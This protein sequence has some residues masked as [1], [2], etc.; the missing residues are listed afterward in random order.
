MKTK[1]KKYAPLLLAILLTST[2]LACPTGHYHPIDQDTFNGHV[3]TL[4]SCESVD[5]GADHN[6]IVE[7]YENP[8]TGTFDE[9][10]ACVLE[11]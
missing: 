4:D 7:N 9:R 2:L 6:C 5:C 10:P 11:E 3:P 8:Q 1:L